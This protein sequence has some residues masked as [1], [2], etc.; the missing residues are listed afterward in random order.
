[1]GTIF[2]WRVT[3]WSS[4]LQWT[5][6]THFWVGYSDA[7]YIELYVGFALTTQTR[8]PRNVTTKQPGHWILEH[9]EI[10]PGCT[11][12]PTL[13]QQTVTWTKAIRRLH[14]HLPRFHWPAHDAERAYSLGPL[15]C[16]SWLRGISPRPR[17]VNHTA[18]TVKLHCC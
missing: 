16:S 13:S 18:A 4:A 10:R 8:S 15:G 2:L 3:Q 17:L 9:I 7:S 11:N 1:M 5:A 14:K 6:A 12:T